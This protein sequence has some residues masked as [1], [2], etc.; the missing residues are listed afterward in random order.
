MNILI[1][2]LNK[3]QWKLAVKGLEYALK[4]DVQIIAFGT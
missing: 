2:Y 4:Y 3:E 1:D